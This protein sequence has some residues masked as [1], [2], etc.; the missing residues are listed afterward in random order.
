MTPGS[1]VPGTQMVQ[2]RTLVDDFLEQT[3]DTQSLNNLSSWHMSKLD[4]VNKI[5]HP[6]DGYPSGKKDVT[7][8]K[9]VIWVLANA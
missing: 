1:Q 3:M 4:S 5:C 8:H 6:L 9:E 7:L 2:G